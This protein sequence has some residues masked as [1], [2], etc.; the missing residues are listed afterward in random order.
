MSLFV[1]FAPINREDELED[2]GG[3]KPNF[4][5]T[6][7]LHPYKVL[8]EFIHNVRSYRVSSSQLPRTFTPF[9]E[10]HLSNIYPDPCLLNI[11]VSN[12]KEPL[13]ADYFV[14]YTSSA[15]C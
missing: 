13:E 9:T 6:P 5:M 1:S 12:F 2:V 7:A 4:S 10:I 8:A 3:W 14:L 11:P 15:Q